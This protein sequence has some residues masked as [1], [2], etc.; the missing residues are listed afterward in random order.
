MLK[1]LNKLHPNTKAL[2]VTLVFVAAI[3]L[4]T[5]YAQDTWLGILPLLI[6]YL[7]LTINSY[8]S[9]RLFSAITPPDDK[10][11][12]AVDLLLGCTYLFLAYSIDTPAVF[13]L[14]T[15]LLFVVAPMKYALLLNNIPHPK[16]L[17]KKIIIDLGGT[18]LSGAVIAGYL[19][20]YSY[21]SAWALA[22]VFAVANFYLLV[23]NPM[24]RLI[25]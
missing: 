3:I 11:Q 13:F 2:F 17:K 1:Q 21:E 18:F 6:F 15:L 22:V 4:G 19:W 16:L 20:G 25:D 5:K 7:V 24:Y 10:G 14:T 8:F 9:I 12:L 23:V